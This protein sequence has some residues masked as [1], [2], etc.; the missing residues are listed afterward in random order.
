VYLCI[1]IVYFVYDSY[2]NNNSNRCQWSALRQTKPAFFLG[3]HLFS[4]KIDF[5]R[6]AWGEDTYNLPL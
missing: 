4:Q 2:T 1:F 5:L 6:S 3:M